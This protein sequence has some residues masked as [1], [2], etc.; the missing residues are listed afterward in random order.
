MAKQA[1]WELVNGRG[2]CGDTYRLKVPGGWLYRER[3]CGGRDA[4]TT[5]IAY[6]F[7]PAPAVQ[8]RKP[9]RR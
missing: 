4:I 5:A 9:K 8:R 6:A 7:V 1:E 2:L 3:E